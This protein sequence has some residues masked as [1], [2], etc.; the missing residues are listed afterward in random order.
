MPK[1]RWHGGAAI[2]HTGKTYIFGRYG[3][4]NWLK[5]MIIYDSEKKEWTSG[6]D[7]SAANHFFACKYHCIFNK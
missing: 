5:D 1:E 6:N 4:S 3:G 2:D 7:I